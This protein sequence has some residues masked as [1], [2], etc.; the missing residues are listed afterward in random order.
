MTKHGYR[1][2]VWTEQIVGGHSALHSF[3]TPAEAS[4]FIERSPYAVMATARRQIGPTRLVG[5]FAGTRVGSPWEQ[6]S[7]GD[8][9]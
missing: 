4:A 2:A 8:D 1:Y 6:W 9:R 7:P 5:G 3:D